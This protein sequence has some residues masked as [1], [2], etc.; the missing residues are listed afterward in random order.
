MSGRYA[1][2]K[3]SQLALEDRVSSGTEP[4]PARSAL[5]MFT[6]RDGFPT[7]RLRLSDRATADA[8]ARLKRLRWAGT[9]S[10][11]RSSCFAD[12]TVTKYMS[13][14]SPR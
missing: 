8:S 12:S 13:D 9:I 11:L 1:H 5:P 10:I 7:T 3:R 4:G 14:K 2:A 6:I